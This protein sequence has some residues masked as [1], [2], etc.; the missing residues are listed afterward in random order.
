MHLYKIIPNMSLKGMKK[1][2]HIYETVA[3][4]I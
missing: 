3:P 2:L 1:T 4:F